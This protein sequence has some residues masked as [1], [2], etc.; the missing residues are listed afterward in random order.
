MAPAGTKRPRD[1]SEVTK[2]RRLR[3]KNSPTAARKPGPFTIPSPNS[4][5]A[6]STWRRVC[7]VS[8]CSRGSSPN[9]RFRRSTNSSTRCSKDTPCRYSVSPSNRRSPKSST[10]PRTSSSRPAGIS[11]LRFPISRSRTRSSALRSVRSNLSRNSG[12]PRVST[13]SSGRSR[14]VPTVWPIRRAMRSISFG[15]APCGNTRIFP[16]R[17]GR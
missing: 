7:G 13:M 6:P 12:W 10:V 9:S 8:T 2:S 1:S 16:I 11:D 15:M 4:C 14:C 5:S 3:S 17:S